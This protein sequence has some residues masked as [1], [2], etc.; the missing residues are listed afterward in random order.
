MH[1]ES[2]MVW[3]IQARVP[4]KSCFFHWRR[5]MCMIMSSKNQHW[6]PISSMASTFWPNHSVHCFLL[7]CSQSQNGAPTA[8]F[9]RCSFE[10]CPWI[11][12][13]L[14]DWPHPGPHQVFPWHRPSDVETTLSYAPR[15]FRCSWQHRRRYY[16]ENL[17]LSPFNTKTSTIQPPCSP[18]SW[19]WW[20][21]G[22]TKEHRWSYFWRCS[23]G[24]ELDNDVEF[25]WLYANFWLDSRWFGGEWVDA[26]WT[27]S[28]PVQCSLLPGLRP[29]FSS[30][31]TLRGLSLSTMPNGNGGQGIW[32]RVCFGK[33][34]PAAMTGTCLTAT[35]ACTVIV[36][37]SGLVWTCFL[38]QVYGTTWPMFL[39]QCPL[40]PVQCPLFF[41]QCPLFALSTTKPLNNGHWIFLMH[42]FVSLFMHPIVFPSYKFKSYTIVCD[43]VYWLSLSIR[44]YLILFKV[45]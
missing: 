32:N 12:C 40:F 13:T 5:V 19:R 29:C 24:R 44:L 7:Q 18:S 36:W 1:H 2:T 8:I 25:A 6:Q 15:T 4:A 10:L 21:N 9:Q 34:A 41:V 27:V 31:L 43:V 42:P 33:P 28:V 45:L 22:I 16:G 38:T 26:M 35:A 37:I 3:G 11:V 20:V 23:S 17:V 14:A 39:V 30:W